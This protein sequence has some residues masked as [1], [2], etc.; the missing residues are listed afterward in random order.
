QD[1]SEPHISSMYC[2]FCRDCLAQGLLGRYDYVDG[3]MIAKSCIHML[4]AYR[5]WSI[6]IPVSYSYFVGVPALVGAPHAK[7]Y[8][9]SELEDFKESLEEWTGRAITNDDLDRGI[10]IVN[11]TRRHLRQLYELR[12]PHPPLFSG[13]E[14]TALVLSAQLTDKRELNPMLA[15]LLT[16]L[17]QRHEGPQP[18]ARIMVVGSET[19]D[20][21]FLRLVESRGANIVIEEQCTGSRY[22]WTEVIPEEDRLSAIAQR[23]VSRPRC[24]LKDVNE[25]R[26]LDHILSLAREFNVQG[27]LLVQQKFCAPHEFEI[28]HIS[29]MLRDNGI[30]T[31]LLELDVTIHRGSVATRTEAFLEMLE[32]E[33]V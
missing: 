8:L 18:E 4:Q 17:P 30:P 9:R 26:R 29:R 27:A 2:S 16:D 11:T 23:F 28:P 10:E 22:F 5:S 1:V 15:Q 3:V 19:M 12:K 6:H 13:A 31:Y 14:A 7:E 25:R 33:A 32:L 24:P 21:E 20:L